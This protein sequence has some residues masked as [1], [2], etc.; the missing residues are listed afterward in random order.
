MQNRLLRGQHGMTLVELMV[1]VA[2]I[3]VIAAIG[4]TLYQDI[5]KKAKLA[6]D[7]ANVSALRSAVAIYYGKTNGFFPTSTVLDV[8]VIPAPVWI[9]GTPAYDTGNGKL[10]YTA[11]VGDCP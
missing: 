2:I 10:S 5:A 6:S 11:T 8:L 1:V 4:M 9:C 7:E 3:A